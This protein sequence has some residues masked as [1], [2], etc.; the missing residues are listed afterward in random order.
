MKIYIKP[1]IEVLELRLTE[2]LAA[3]TKYGDPNGTG[4]LT[5][6]TKYSMNVN[7]GSF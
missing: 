1:T 4:A 7:K 6:I 2:N 3:T 5:P